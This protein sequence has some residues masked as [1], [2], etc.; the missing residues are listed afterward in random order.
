MVVMV[1][2]KDADA[3]LAVGGGRSD[4]QTSIH[5]S[6]VDLSGILD[7]WAQMKF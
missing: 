4:Q 1:E 3:S 5:S 6:A 7:R 2:W